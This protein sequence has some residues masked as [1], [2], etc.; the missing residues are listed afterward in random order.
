M[1]PHLRWELSVLRGE[2]DV[3]FPSGMNFGA[4]G[5]HVI[6]PGFL[7]DG[8]LRHARR[9]RLRGDRI[10][11]RD[12]VPV[13]GSVGDAPDISV[14]VERGS[15][16]E[17]VISQRE[18]V[19]HAGSY[20]SSAGQIADHDRGFQLQGA[21]A[22]ESASLRTYDEYHA[23]LGEGAHAIETR[24]SD[25]NLDSQSRAAPRRFRGVYF[26][27]REKRPG[28]LSNCG[29]FIRWGDGDEGNRR[30]G[31]VVISPAPGIEAFGLRTVPHGGFA[32]V[33]DDILGDIA[34]HITAYLEF[35]RACAT[36]AD[37]P[38]CTTRAKPAWSIAAMVAAAIP[39]GVAAS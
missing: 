27:K 31:G 20:G 13:F 24:H 2:G 7:L 38:F 22:A 12:N 9:L 15:N 21:C 5:E 26:H 4:F 33:Q 19:G 28:L 35:R 14:I 11:L 36:P 25:G 3:L 10:I 32:A 29:R 37:T 6:G 18:T 34:G 39:P 8:R 30:R 17:A 1:K 16:Q 23:P